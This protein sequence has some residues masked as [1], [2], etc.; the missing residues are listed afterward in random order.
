[1]IATRQND[2]IAALAGYGQIV[3][4]LDAAGVFSGSWPRRS[5]DTI[6][7]T[8]NGLATIAHILGQRERAARLFGAAAA[9]DRAIGI[10]PAL[11]ERTLF[12]QARADLRRTFGDEA[13]DEAWN[14]GSL[15]T[16]AE[17]RSEIT[18]ILTADV[19]SV[20]RLPWAAAEFELTARERDVLRLLQERRSDKEIGSALFISHRT[21][22]GHVANILRKL[23]VSSRAAAVQRAEQLGLL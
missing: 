14:L 17:V 1:L 11:P 10:E 9:D 23:G 20:T 2:P 22:M 21:A 18:A 3:E 8:L 5:I 4:W 16:P 15:M 12:E 6:G 19:P 13:F 7:R